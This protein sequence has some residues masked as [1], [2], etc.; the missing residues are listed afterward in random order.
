MK[1]KD[2][3]SLEKILDEEIYNF[4]QL[5]KYEKLKN[6]VIINQEVEKLKQ[7][8]SDEEEIL[9]R[10]AD[11]EEK[12]EHVVDDLFTEYSVNSEKVLSS[13]IKSL[14]DKEN[15]YKDVLKK[16]KN[17][18]VRNINDLKKINEINNKLLMDSIKFFSYAVNSIQEMDAVVYD[19]DGSMPTDYENSRVI[20]KQA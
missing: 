20:N 9:D 17:E 2:F 3:D 15:D 7:L 5:L 13:L 1:R 12:R 4:K 10:V 6:S 14:P 8:S 19:K 18:L 16:K 11:L